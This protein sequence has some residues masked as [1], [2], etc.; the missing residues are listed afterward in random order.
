MISKKTKKE[1]RQLQPSLAFAGKEN[2]ENLRHPFLS[3]F[4]ASQ[5]LSYTAE[6]L[7]SPISM[8][9][10]KNH[11]LRHC[12]VPSTEDWD[13]GTKDVVPDYRDIYEGILYTRANDR[14]Q[15]SLFLDGYFH[16][17]KGVQ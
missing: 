13:G 12:Y 6:K 14:Y 3:M 4:I 16:D 10:F 8:W 1:V 15:V 5:M 17:F 11:L 2:L 9:S 7:R